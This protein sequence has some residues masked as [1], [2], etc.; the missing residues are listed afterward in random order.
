VTE[1]SRPARTAPIWDAPITVGLLAVGVINTIQT[2]AQAR[3]LPAALD[4]VY[5]ARGISR[6]TQVGL[7]T[8]IGW[9]VAIAAIGGLVLAIGFSV[10]RIRDHRLAFWIPLAAGAASAVVTV[11]L[12]AAAILADPAYL[13]S[14][15]HATPAP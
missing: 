14:I 1:T 3:E 5:A 15:R 2:V 12:V 9:V 10:P 4:Q 6:Y 13:D 8:G 7:A 11:V